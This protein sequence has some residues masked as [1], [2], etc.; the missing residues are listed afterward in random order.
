[1]TWVTCGTGVVSDVHQRYSG[2]E[3]EFDPEKSVEKW[4]K[5]NLLDPRWIESDTTYYVKGT[6]WTGEDVKD[7]YDE[8]ILGLKLKEALLLRTIQ[9]TQLDRHALICCETMRDHEFANR[10]ERSG[11]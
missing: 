11:A 3:G 1:M 2:L 9:L 10:I 7:G 4:F 6:D 8:V 5:L